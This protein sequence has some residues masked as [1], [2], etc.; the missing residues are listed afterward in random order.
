MLAAHC[1]SAGPPGA[2]GAWVSVSEAG[3]WAALHEGV[4]V[5]AVEDRQLGRGDIGSKKK[6]GDKVVS[7]RIILQPSLFCDD[8]FMFIT[9]DVFQF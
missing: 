6:V 9:I 4:N 2:A 8:C 3:V 7:F 1:G 5:L